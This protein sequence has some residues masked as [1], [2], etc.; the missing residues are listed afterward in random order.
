MGE[1]LRVL[2]VEDSGDDAEM[3]CQALRRGGYDAICEQVQTAH[4]LNAALDR[5]PWDIVLADYTLPQ[6]DGISALQLIRERGFDTPFIFV[7]GS[8]GED[9]AVE[10][11]KAGAQDYILKG[12]LKR[13]VPAVEREL[14]EAE[15]RRQRQRTQNA[16]RE[17]TVA[18]E[19]GSLCLRTD[20]LNVVMSA[21]VRLIADALKV[22]F[23]E[24]VLSDTSGALR[25]AAG[26]GW[27][28]ALPD[29][30][31]LAASDDQI[32]YTLRAESP[33]FVEDA[34]TDSRLN[35]SRSRHPD[36][37][38]SS[39]SV[40]MVSRGYAI[41]VMAVH[42]KTR[43]T[44]RPD[45]AEFLQ[46]VSSLVAVAIDRKQAE[47]ALRRSE[48]RFSGI[49]DIAHE[50]IISIDD[51]HR[52]IMFNKGAE[53]LFGYSAPAALGQS[54]ELLLPERFRDGH[55]RHI[56]QFAQSDGPARLMTERGLIY[57]RKQTGDEFPAEA[58]ISKLRVAGETIFTVVLRDVTETKQAEETLRRA[59]DELEVRV[60]ERT[61]DLEQA[62]AELQ[63]A[64]EELTAL[65][66]MKSDFISMV[67][68]EVRTPLTS[69]KNAV[70]LLA[71]EETGSLTGTQQRFL[72]MAI[73]NIDRLVKMINDV[74]DFSKIEAGKLPFRF[75][76]MELGP[77]ITQCAATFQPQA[78][79]LSLTI[80]V[81][82]P[83]DLPTAYVDPD[84]IEQ[85]LSNLVS[86]ALKFTPRGGQIVVSARHDHDQEMVEVSVADTGSGLSP[87]DQSRVFD[88]FYQVGDSLT[89]SAKGT[90]L[91]LP[92]A[93]ELVEDHGGAI[94]VESEEGRGSRFFFRLPVFSPSHAESILLD[95]AI[96]S[97]P[98]HSGALLVI[99][100]DAD[101]SSDSGALPPPDARVWDQAAQVIRTALRR[102]S[103][104]LIVQP[105]S[106]RLVLLLPDTSKP[107]AVVVRGR[108]ER[109]LRDGPFGQPST[110]A[111]PII[112]GPVMY[113]EDGATAASLI[114]KA[115][116]TTHHRT[117]ETNGPANDSRG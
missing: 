60:R 94:S 99:E 97:H 35:G 104:H 98:G 79:S 91:G 95:Q 113:P 75:S 80:E 86:N 88:R 23:C 42:S 52:I 92:I 62:A 40:P 82:C 12:H 21:A 28:G 96:K 25:P 89:R 31:V 1:P 59:R 41:G 33:V 115:R 93:K 58:S 8:L 16:L 67:S 85:V 108:V 11:L 87:D 56:E 77:L 112:R 103:D 39:L 61:A 83:P 74:L 32:R 55:D 106:R 63:E 29:A 17:S 65:D 64:N 46:A 22:S 107:G 30:A 50:A 24:I 45:E 100:G 84:R 68:H 109:A 72:A 110:E 36:Q 18:S 6:F 117:E 10:A 26:A 5:Q 7:T 20:D 49:L 27:D 15:N 3:L 54:I 70:D 81:V 105:A 51:R 57:G 101:G 14:R 44:F 114:A 47:E 19:I 111:M 69:I 43:R 78:E 76:E 34:A 4:A 9:R 71:A 116:E 2:I 48:A 38:V 102:G 73:R 53:H 13:L 37:P 90:G 66:Q